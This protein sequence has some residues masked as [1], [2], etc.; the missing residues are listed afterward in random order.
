MASGMVWVPHSQD[1]GL[2]KGAFQ[3][4]VSIEQMFRE[5]QAGVHAFSDQVPEANQLQKES[6]LFQP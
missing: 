3:E 4:E 6:G 5:N 2:Q 1:S